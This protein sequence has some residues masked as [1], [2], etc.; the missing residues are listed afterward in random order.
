MKQPRVIATAIILALGVMAGCTQ[1]ADT[2]PAD[3]AK[4]APATPAPTPDHF[5]ADTG[6]EGTL[7]A[8]FDPSWAFAVADPAALREE[9]LAVVS[10]RVIGVE[11]S[12]IDGNATVSTAYSVQVRTVYKG[13]DIADV[14]SVSQPGGTM[15]LSE[16]IAA[17]DEMGMYERVLGFKDLDGDAGNGYQDARTMDPSFPVT[18][19]LGLNPASATT[20]AELQPDNWVFY[21]GGSEY[22]SYYNT[23]LN[24]GMKYLKD[25]MVH[26]LP[27]EM[28]VPTFPEADLFEE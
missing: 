6:A 18:A 9:S 10:G 5:V 28:D 15:S 2:S 25:G 13:E 16:Y 17:L 22:G 12:F 3:G 11:R 27:T 8:G 20:L 1:D 4:G 7:P 14:I 23:A 24:Y 21:L 26:S 19:N